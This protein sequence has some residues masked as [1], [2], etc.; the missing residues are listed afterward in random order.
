MKLKRITLDNMIKRK[1]QIKGASA[2]GF[3]T[4]RDLPQNFTRSKKNYFLIRPL[5]A[6]VCFSWNYLNI[7]PNTYWCLAANILKR[8]RSFSMTKS[9]PA[10]R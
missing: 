4:Q 6:H 7:F 3:F 8:F 10:L 9:Q 1:D 2:A 5:E